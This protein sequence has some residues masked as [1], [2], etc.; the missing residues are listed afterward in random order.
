MEGGG[1][2]TEV[3]LVE[4]PGEA[5]TDDREAGKYAAKE[6]KEAEGEP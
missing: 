1:A 4:A 6:E 3:E 2:G 5:V